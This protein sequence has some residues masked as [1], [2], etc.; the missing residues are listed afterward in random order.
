MAVRYSGILDGIMAADAANRADDERKSDQEKYDKD[1]E[2]QDKLWTRQEEQFSETNRIR[3]LDMA[4]KYANNKRKGS[5]TGNNYKVA[6]DGPTIAQSL[7]QL[8]QFNIPDEAIDKVSGGTAAD[9]AKIVKSFTTARETH[10]KEYGDTS[11]MSNEMFVTALNEAIVTQPEGY[12]VDT[13]AILKQFGITATDAERLMFPQNVEQRDRVNL[14]AGSLNIV[15]GFS[16]KDLDP[17]IRAVG[18]DVVITASQQL[19]KYRNV[20]ESEDPVVNQWRT[21]RIGEIETGISKATGEIPDL[22]DLFSL[23]GNAS[24]LDYI[25]NDH[26]L[27]NAIETGRFPSSYAEA[28]EQSDID[29]TVPIDGVG[30]LSEHGLKIYNYLMQNK[31][32]PLGTRIKFIKTDGSE[33][34]HLVTQELLAE[35]NR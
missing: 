31:L 11:P 27:K 33:Y 7:A 30:N 21:N 34:N 12:T 19:R 24:A 22:T 10:I 16:F 20:D 6:A 32:V 15:P 2:R 4:L 3:L 23:F 17:A 5:F 25:N 28:I 26:I 18:T 8:K 9:L 1:Q 35:H 29:L 14:A 13:D